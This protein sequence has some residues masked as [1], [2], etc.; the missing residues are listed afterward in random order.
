M[1]YNFL[2]SP[3]LHHTTTPHHTIPTHKR[4]YEAIVVELVKNR[5]ETEQP[6]NAVLSIHK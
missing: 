1:I 4:E 5:V 6:Q 2:L 3:L